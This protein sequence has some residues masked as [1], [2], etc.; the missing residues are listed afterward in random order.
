[1]NNPMLLTCIVC[2]AVADGNTRQADGWTV[3]PMNE[4]KCSNCNGNSQAE[5]IYI[6]A[7]EPGKFTRWPKKPAKGDRQ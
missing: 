6:P 3:V 5:F 2:G 7:T 1:M 4:V